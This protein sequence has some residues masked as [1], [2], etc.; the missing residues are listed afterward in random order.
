ML[1]DDGAVTELSSSGVGI[2]GNQSV[3]PGMK[4]TLFIDLLGRVILHYPEH[5]SWVEGYRFGVEMEIST[6]G[7]KNHLAILLVNS[8]HS[9]DCG[10][11]TKLRPSGNK[12]PH[13]ETSTSRIWK[14]ASVCGQSE[15]RPLG[16][17]L[18]SDWGSYARA[19]QRGFHE[20]WH[21]SWISHLQ[22]CASDATSMSKN[23]Q[24]FFITPDGQDPLFVM[25]PRVAWASERRFE[26]EILKMI[27]RNG[28]RLRY[29]LRSNLA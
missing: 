5:V 20:R 12:G 2:R 7:E 13:H 15:T 28:N 25:E 16:P 23:S 4:V 19:Y 10:Y 18:S 17:R 27:C 3:T 29:F 22:D 26:V 21:G 1:I 8:C 9:P 24:F 14:R 11:S 6:L